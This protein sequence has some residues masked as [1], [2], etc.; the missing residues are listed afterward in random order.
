MALLSKKQILEAQD[1]KIIEV[2]CPEWKGT[3]RIKSLTGAERDAFEDSIMGERDKAGTREV[4]MKNLRAKLVAMA[5]VDKDGNPLFTSG[6]VLALGQKNAAALDRLFTIAQKLAGI[7]KDD[8]EEMV[9]NSEP[10]Q[11]AGS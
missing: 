1:Q 11:A 8:L 6:D 2:D 4:V 5:A 7:T 3:V 9:K 10:G